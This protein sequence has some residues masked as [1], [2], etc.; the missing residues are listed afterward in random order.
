MVQRD[1]T[2]PSVGQKGKLKIEKITSEWLKET[3]SGFA[4]VYE[5]CALK[6][7]RCPDFPGSVSG[8]KSKLPRGQAVT[9]SL[10]L[11]S[12]SWGSALGF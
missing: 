2:V 8:R 12:R 3:R 4:T 6:Q 10:W 7:E 5:R 11:S 9:L 1:G